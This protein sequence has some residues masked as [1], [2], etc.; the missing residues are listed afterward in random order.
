MTS[1]SSIM[2]HPCRG[3]AGPVRLDGPV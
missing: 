3:A 2:Q 1:E